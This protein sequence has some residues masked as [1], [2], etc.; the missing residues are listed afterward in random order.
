M[1]CL[2]TIRSK[3]VCGGICVSPQMGLE[4]LSLA[5]GK[6]GEVTVRTGASP[7][8]NEETL[9]RF[10]FNGRVQKSKQQGRR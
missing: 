7:M 3:T 8:P 5:A 4:R 9:E 2:A 10:A 1:V 6:Y